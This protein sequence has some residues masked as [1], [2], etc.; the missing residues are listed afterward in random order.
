MSMIKP[1]VKLICQ[2]C[3]GG[4]EL[5]PCQLGRG[6]GK[7]CSKECA[8]T[9]MQRGS[10]LHCSWCD[11]VFYRAASEQSR[12]ETYFCSKSCYQEHRAAYIK[13]STYKKDGRRHEHRVVAERILG[14]TLKSEEVVHHID[15]NKHNNAPENLVV[16]PNQSLHSRCHKGSLPSNDL[17]KYRL[18]SHG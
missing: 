1:R 8:H 4:F 15:C 13:S 17:E 9:A 2:E 5:L 7:Y 11:S 10:E 14:R 6:R 18:V 16:F 3:G 12:A